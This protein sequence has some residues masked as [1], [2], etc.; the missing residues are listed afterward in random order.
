MS[1]SKRRRWNKVFKYL[2][3]RFLDWNSGHDLRIEI[4]FSVYQKMMHWVRLAGNVEVSGFGKVERIRNVFHIIDVVLVDQHNSMAS[5]VLDAHALNKAEYEMRDL[6]GEFNFWWHSHHYM[7]AFFSSTDD[8]TIYEIGKE[9]WLL[10][11]VVNA[12]G[13]HEAAL[14]EKKGEPCKLTKNIPFYI[15]GDV[16][17]DARKTWN[18]SYRSCVKSQDSWF[19][20]S[21]THSASADVVAAV[22]DTFQEDDRRRV[23]VDKNERDVGGG[24]VVGTC[25]LAALMELVDG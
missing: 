18:A 24:A 19:A 9:G 5:T 14:Y 16:D 12:L 17:V 23:E 21:D 25:P 4:P 20:P 7:Q 1:R 3:N 15:T 22:L 8:E 6:R 2:N 10:A 11:L 13:Q